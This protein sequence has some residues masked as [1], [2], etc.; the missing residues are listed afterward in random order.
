MISPV[1]HCLQLWRKLIFG[2]AEGEG[3]MGERWGGGVVNNIVYSAKRRKQRH[4]LRKALRVPS[5]RNGTDTNCG[6]VEIE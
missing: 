3:G 6:L 2:G 4:A 1:V 5:P